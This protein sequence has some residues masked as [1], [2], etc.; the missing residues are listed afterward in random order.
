MTAAALAELDAALAEWAAALASLAAAGDD[1]HD[2]DD[3][4]H[5]PGPSDAAAGRVERDPVTSPRTRSR[6]ALQARSYAVPVS[7]AC[8]GARHDR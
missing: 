2:E 7:G 4:Q 3:P 6:T 1:G 5:V 8:A